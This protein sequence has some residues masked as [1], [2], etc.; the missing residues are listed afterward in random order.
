MVAKKWGINVTRFKESDVQ[1]IQ[2]ADGSVH[3]GLVRRLCLNVCRTTLVDVPVFVS[4]KPNRMV[5]KAIEKRYFEKLNQVTT[6][7]A[8][9][10]A[11]P[12]EVAKRPLTRNVLG[13]EG[14]LDKLLICLDSDGAYFFAD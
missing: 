11:A 7:S 12:V 5:E 10:S 2:L 8:P 9:R 4:V 14:V 6:S 1:F 13:I 3:V